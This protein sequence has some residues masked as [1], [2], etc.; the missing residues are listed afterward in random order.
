MYNYNIRKKIQVGKKIAKYIMDFTA[1][2]IVL[3]KWILK[4]I[5]D[6]FSF[7]WC[8]ISIF[9]GDRGSTRAIKFL[10]LGYMHCT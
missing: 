1:G 10:Q 3:I 4:G 8:Y 9:G 5:D 7:F 2:N 6:Y